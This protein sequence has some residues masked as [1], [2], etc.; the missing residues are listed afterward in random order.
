MSV[1]WPLFAVDLIFLF[2]FLFGRVSFSLFDWFT[3]NYSIF[4]D[5][6]YRIAKLFRSNSGIFSC[7]VYLGFTSTLWLFFSLIWPFLFTLKFNDSYFSIKL[8]PAL[9]ESCLESNRFPPKGLRTISQLPYRL[10]FRV[11]GLHCRL[12]GGNWYWLLYL[13]LI[14][15]FDPAMI[16]YIFNRPLGLVNFLNVGFRVVFYFTGTGIT[17]RRKDLGV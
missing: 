15:R 6:F 12:A 11:V 10:S 14:G 5:W 17:G 13:M 3:C 9:W 7:L 16:S 2:P 4:Y 8:F 1:W